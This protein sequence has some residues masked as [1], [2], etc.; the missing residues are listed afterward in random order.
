MSGLL[1]L[2]VKIGGMVGSQREE[3]PATKALGSACCRHPRP[4]GLSPVPT[5]P[6]MEMST[7][8]RDP[9]WAEKEGRGLGKSQGKETSAEAASSGK[10]SQT[11]RQVATSPQTP[12]SLHLR[13]PGR[14]QQVSWVLP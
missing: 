6:L 8:G 4:L 2:E 11:E 7:D 14:I 12:E 13:V 3:A 10:S 5:F 1:G 9:Q